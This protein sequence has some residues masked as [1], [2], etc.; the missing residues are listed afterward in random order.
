MCIGNIAVDDF[1]RVPRF[2]QDGDVLPAEH[3]GRRLG[4]GGFNTA[5]ALARLGAHVRFVTLLG[6]DENADFARREMPGV[7]LDLRL[8]EIPGYE[9]KSPRVLVTSSGQ[10]ATFFQADCEPPSELE[11]I[12]ADLAPDE[13][14]A[15]YSSMSVPGHTAYFERF[16]GPRV[17]S[18]EV[19]CLPL[20]PDAF[21]WG[22]QAADVLIL[23]RN[24]FRAVLA[25]EV[26]AQSMQHGMAQREGRTSLVIVT[27]GADGSLTW[28]RDGQ[29]VLTTPAFPVEVVDSTGAG[30]VFNAAFVHGYYVRQLALPEALRFAHAVASAKCEDFGTDLSEGALRKA[31]TLLA[32]DCGAQATV[33]G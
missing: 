15:I 17:V 20:F 21:A 24:S 1:Y 9:I 11:R 28:V 22:L 10:K 19:H 27:L 7:G 29:Q 33:A 12:F 6:D 25:E 26:S 2:P 32:T 4:G 30:D 16:K 3:V 13:A 31:A 18:I 14:T 5:R 8:L 23:D